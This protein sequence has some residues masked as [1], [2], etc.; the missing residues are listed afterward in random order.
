MEISNKVVLVVDDM[1]LT[2]VKLRQ[3][4]NEI[5]I[6]KIYEAADGIEALKVL[7]NVG[8]HLILT[9][10]MMPRMAGIDLLRELRKMDRFAQTPVIFITAES[11][12]NAILMSVVSGVTDYIVK[13]FSD[14]IVKQKIMTSLK[15]AE[16]KEKPK[17]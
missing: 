10:W 4:C 16:P 6:T 3:I 8:V 14:D 9:D 17:A 7:A 15:E 5:G 11:D 1:K 12:K 2:R 13:P